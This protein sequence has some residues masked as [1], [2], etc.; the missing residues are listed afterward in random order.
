MLKIDFNSDWQYRCIGEKGKGVPVTLPHDGMAG[1]E[2]SADW[3][4]DGGV[5]DGEYT[6][7]FFLPQEDRGKHFTFTFDGIYRHAEVYINGISVLN[8]PCGHAGFQIFA[9]RFLKFGANNELKVIA[10]AVGGEKGVDCVGITRPVYLYVSDRDCICPNGVR[11]RTLRVHP[12][13]VE[14]A[15]RTSC[16]GRVGVEF[17][18]EGEVI[19]SD[20]GMNKGKEIVFRI[21]VPYAAL[22]SVDNPSLYTCRVTFATDVWEEKFG[23]RTLSC[24]KDVGFSINGERVVL[25][26]VCLR[27]GNGM[28][29]AC[30]YPEAE[31]RKL[32]LLKSSGY[33]AVRCENAPCS[34][35]MLELCDRLG[36]LVVDECANVFYGQ[37]GGLKKNGSVKKWQKRELAYMIERDRNHPS[38][39]MYSLGDELAERGEKQRKE[40]FKEGKEICTLLDADRPVT[41]GV[42][43]ALNFFHV[44][45]RDWNMKLSFLKKC[46]V[47]LGRLVEFFG[48]R[49]LN[50]LALLPGCE[51]W[52]KEYYAAVDVAGYN[53]G[54]SRY[55]HDLEK[56]PD[57][58][59]VGSET[60]YTDGYR[61]REMSKSDPRLIGTFVRTEVDCLDGTVGRADASGTGGFLRE[62]GWVAAGK[63]RCDLIGIPLGETLYGKVAFEQED[64]PM[65]A[66]APVELI[67]EK[68]SFASRKVSTLIPSW[69]WGGMEDKE[70][71]VE[72][73]SRAPQV[74]LYLNG[75]A[76]GKK[77]RHKDCRFVFRIRYYGGE[78]TA[79]ALDGAGKELSRHSLYSAG[80]KTCL[81]V[82]PERMEIGPGRITFVPLKY[83]DCNYNWKPLENGTLRVEVTGGELL[84][85]GNSRGQSCTDRIAT[86]YGTAMAAVRATDKKIVISVTDG[87]RMSSAE[88]T[89]RERMRRRF[90]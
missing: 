72:V 33:N 37:K 42:N 19:Y 81:S 9:D 75:L 61:F 88:I 78:L 59:I 23:I 4:T 29:G 30:A 90:R 5:G 85:L 76:V 65:I 27:A 35:S 83:T 14:V 69:S 28:L 38:V 58:I 40:F 20:S 49:F 1:R 51:R 62:D 67:K 64:R 31:E 45:S 84:A 11:I 13:V 77:H 55:R 18:F 70:M 21:E 2:S 71:R 26:G 6:K 68:Q 74:A 16:P 32:R 48:E 79:I 15:V 43:L 34:E 3:L 41:A 10:R 60:F 25:R 82:M 56:Y 73:Y 63:S 17:L 66:V 7:V 44:F 36:M 52:A 53:Y 12:A 87:K 8:R 50:L 22:W 24:N 89:V 46:A 86:H 39:V 54:I 47:V 80:E 57:R